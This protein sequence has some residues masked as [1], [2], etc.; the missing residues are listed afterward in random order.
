MKESIKKDVILIQDGVT[1]TIIPK[2]VNA[3]RVLVF[4]LW[5]KEKKIGSMSLIKDL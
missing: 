1:K 4:N 3:T 5:Y 2:I